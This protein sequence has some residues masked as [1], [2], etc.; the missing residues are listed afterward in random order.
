[1][2]INRAFTEYG[3]QINDFKALTNHDAQVLPA[4]AKVTTNT[5]KQANKSIVFSE[6]TQKISHAVEFNGEEKPD[7]A[8]LEALRQK[9]DAG[10]YHVDINQLTDKL[11]TEVKQTEK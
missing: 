9:I 11:M 4:K 10:E 8:K 3:K 5:D 6:T 1:M 2:N 7:M